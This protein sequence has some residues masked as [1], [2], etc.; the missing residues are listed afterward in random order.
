MYSA[1]GAVCSAVVDQQIGDD[2]VV[3]ASGGQK[4]Q[5]WAIFD[6]R[7]VLH[8]PPFTDEG[9]LWC[10]RGSRLQTQVLHLHIKFLLNAFIVI[11]IIYLPQNKY[12]LQYNNVK[13]RYDNQAG[14]LQV[15]A[16]IS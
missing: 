9:R 4:P 13:T 7:G 8:R 10:A 5:F 15:T 11:I 14:K 1:S 12:R 6:I 2:A 3:S 16:A